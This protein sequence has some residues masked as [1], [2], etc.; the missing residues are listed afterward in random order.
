[1]VGFRYQ[2]PTSI[3]IRQITLRKPW[4]LFERNTDGSFELASLIRVPDARRTAPAPAAANRR[5][6]RRRSACSSAR[7][8]WRTALC[9]SWTARRTP[10]SPRSC[11]P[12]S[13]TAEG[14]GTRP[15]RHAKV[16]LRAD[17]R[18]RHPAVHP[19]R[20]SAASRGRT[21]S[22]SRS[23]SPSIPVPRLNPYMDHLLAWIAQGRHAHR[24]PSLPALGRRS[25]GR[26]RR[27]PPGA[28]P[29]ARRA[30]RAARSSNA[31]ACRSTRW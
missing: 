24:D 12:C 21:S 11:P 8:R 22:I 15:S 28:R 7:S 16:A 20:R 26:Q 31:S 25:A 4:L 23:R 17:V 6:P 19:G 10:T 1:M 27:D 9:A 30:A 13:L 18:L 2:Y 29:P 5:L 3:R 14:I